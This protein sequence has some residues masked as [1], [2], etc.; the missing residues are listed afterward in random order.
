MI[1]TTDS[2]GNSI[3]LIENFYKKYF[4]F[5]V[6]YSLMKRDFMANSSQPR[7][8]GG[9]IFFYLLTNFLRI[10]LD[11]TSNFGNILENLLVLNNYSFRT[12]DTAESDRF[13]QVK[14]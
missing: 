12:S 3:K 1:N 7:P 9:Q 4:N 11:G 2:Q 6:D 14:F 8:N 10:N 5:L 13:F